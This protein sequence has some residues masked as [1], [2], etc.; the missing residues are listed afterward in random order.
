VTTYAGSRKITSPL[1]QYPKTNRDGTID[2]GKGKLVIDVEKEEQSGRA[3]GGAHMM[4]Y[5]GSGMIWDHQK[6]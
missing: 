6:V 4:G 5:P 3:V 2:K 1:G